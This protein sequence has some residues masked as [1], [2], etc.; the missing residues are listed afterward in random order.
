MGLYNKIAKEISVPK[1][2]GANAGTGRGLGVGA[3]VGSS[4]GGTPAGA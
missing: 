3:G 4:L 2:Q 1:R